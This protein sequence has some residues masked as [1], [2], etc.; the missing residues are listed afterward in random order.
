MRD[1]TL[2]SL[3]VLLAVVFFFLA[4]SVMGGSGP[5]YYQTLQ[6]EDVD[7]TQRD[8]LNLEGAGV[9]C[10]DDGGTKTT[11]TITGGAA[12][13][14]IILDLADDGSNES[15]A[16]TE[17]AT[18]GDTNSIF[19]EPAADKLLI[20]LGL[21]WPAADLAAA[22]AANGA[23]CGAGQAA[24]GV[25]ASGAAESC[26]DPLIST[27]LDSEAELEALLSDVTNVYT[28]NDGALNDD[29]IT[30]DDIADLSDVVITSVA[31]NEVLAYDS[32][33]GDWI[34][35]TAAEAGLAAASHSHTASNISDL[36]AGTD[37]TADL[38]EE[39]H[40]SEHASGGSDVLY[41][42]PAIVWVYQGNVAAETHVSIVNLPWNVT[43]VEAHCVA[44][45]APTTDAV[46][47]QFQEAGVDIFADGDRVSIAAAA[48]EDTSGSPT[49]TTGT[50]GQ[51]ITM[52]I[53][54]ADTGDTA[55]NLTCYLKVKVALS[56]S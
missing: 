41:I 22:L 27:E 26:V 1:R 12:G 8:T 21:N 47:V 18:T 24:G 55:A 51:N 7:L 5:A 23:N 50:A 16:I 45:T 49:D 30:D 13:T 36:H 39:T 46:I 11:C 4:P 40:A 32:G 33:T 9:T 19:T 42:Y 15:T 31:D 53:E 35:Q 54:Q 37:I 48:T 52:I 3:V 29:D 34:N 20:N 10:A 6:D 38:E 14:T 44:G 43:Y 28:N 2:A 56:S 25:D 17:I